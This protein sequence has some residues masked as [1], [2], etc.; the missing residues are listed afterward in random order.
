MEAI[1][2]THNAS[3]D[4]ADSGSTGSAKECGCQNREIGSD[5]IHT[6]CSFDDT[7]RD[8]F[9][10]AGRRRSEEYGEYVKLM[11]FTNG[12]GQTWSYK[13]LSPMHE[14]GF[15]PTI[16]QESSAPCNE[17][18][19]ALGLHAQLTIETLEP[20][21]SDPDGSHTC[22][23]VQSYSPSP[24]S[25]GDISDE[26]PNN[27][28]TTL[29]REITAMLTDMGSNTT[30]QQVQSMNQLDRS[31]LDRPSEVNPV[32]LEALQLSD[33]VSLTS[34]LASLLPALEIE[35]IGA[36]AGRY[37]F[38]PGRLREPLWTSKL[39]TEDMSAI[40]CP[41]TTSF[42][43]R[44]PGVAGKIPSK[45]G[46]AYQLQ[47]RPCQPPL[48]HRQ[49]RVQ[50]S[51]PTARRR[52]GARM[53]PNH[54]VAYP[55]VARNLREQIPATLRLKEPNANQAVLSTSSSAG[56]IEAKSAESHVDRPA[57]DIKK[58]PL[59][60]NSMSYAPSNSYID[61]ST[62]AKLM[63]REPGR[64]H[65]LVPTAPHGLSA[66]ELGMSA[67]THPHRSNVSL[68]LNQPTWP[69]KQVGF[70]R[71]TADQNS[72]T[73]SPPVPVMISQYPHI[74]DGVRFYIP[75]ARDRLML[76]RSVSHT[77][78]SGSNH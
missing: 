10:K 59:V 45:S 69:M 56:V 15:P 14:D 20:E 16:R 4:E 40:G 77:L 46:S 43:E 72:I 75:S 33:T 68:L 66:R 38:I 67:T 41:L 21:L 29:S 73:V 12:D 34:Y 44:N 30:P 47:T 3:A 26:N 50:S 39:S 2:R 24:L 36:G 65:H 51:D 31:M 35:R 6:R 37:N 5:A 1:L 76:S 11:S 57:Y 48:A 61:A 60:P 8:A 9:D 52:S 19:Y 17:P 70:D 27:I 55:P 78:S 71:R 64:R 62:Y 22:S 32:G 74:N 18:N 13:V 63:A 49:N 25:S 23:N 54:P 42:I 28:S 53:P 58:L 7:V